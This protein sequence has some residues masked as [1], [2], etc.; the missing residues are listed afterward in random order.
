MSKKISM[1]S[2]NIQENR[3]IK[4]LDLTSNENWLQE[5]AQCGP[6]DEISQI[7][8]D[9]N[10]IE[11]I[12]GPMHNL[13]VLRDKLTLLDL[14]FNL[15]KDLPD[16]FSELS[17]LKELNLASNRLEVIPRCLFQLENLEILHLGRGEYS[18]IPDELSSLGNLRY[19]TIASKKSIYK[20]PMSVYELKN[21]EE[22]NLLG[23]ESAEGV[24]ENISKLTNLKKFFFTCNNMTGFER[25][26]FSFE[27]SK[28]L[29]KGCEFS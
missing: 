9:R 15:L 18:E 17:Q 5:L 14:S 27:I 10:K 29:P 2:V 26:A 16:N 1:P 24:I 8:L 25:K 6:D 22:L 21:L 28:V 13:I 3:G 12:N 11:E 7:F 4:Y 23:F 20:V 19:L